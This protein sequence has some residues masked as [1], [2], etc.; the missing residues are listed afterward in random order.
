[1][2]C[3]HPE[4]TGVHDNSRWSELCPRSRAAKRIKDIRYTSQT[5]IHIHRFQLALQR[6]AMKTVR[7]GGRYSEVGKMLGAW[8]TMATDWE[9]DRAKMEAYWV[10]NH[11]KT[12]E[13]WRD[14]REGKRGIRRKIGTICA[15]R[16]GVISVQQVMAATRNPSIRTYYH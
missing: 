2:I 9:E 16:N 3:T 1:M 13:D 14:Q 6:G 11:A 5:L 15:G 7:P 10:T 8:S 12:L 4:C